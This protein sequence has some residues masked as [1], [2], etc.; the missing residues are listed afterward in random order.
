MDVNVL[1]T[2]TEIALL[3]TLHLPTPEDIS[4][5]EARVTQTADGIDDIDGE[6]CN[7]RA[8]INALKS[9]G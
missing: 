2:Q 8:Q 1:V 9:P 7:L 5:F 3:R 4:D 6:I